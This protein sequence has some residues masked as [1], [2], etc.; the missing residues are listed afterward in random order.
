RWP[1]LSVIIPARNEANTLRITLPSLLSFYYPQA[2]IILVD[3]CS[4]DGTAQVAQEVAAAQGRENLRIITETEPPAGWRGKVWALE[5]GVRASTGE[6]LLFLDG[7]VS[8]TPHMPRDLLRSALNR[9]YRMASLMVLLRMESFWDR[10]LVPAFVF[11]FHTLYPFHWV[12]RDRSRTA[13]AAGG[14]ILIERAALVEAGG[15]E[16]VRDAWI[17]DVALAKRVKQNGAKVYLGITVQ[18]MSVR[19]YGTLES[20]RRMVTRSAF[21]QLQHSWILLGLTLAVMAVLFGVPFVDTIL[22]T[23]RLI[24]M[25]SVD[26]VFLLSASSGFS[27]GFMITAYSPFLRLYRMPVVW[28]LTLPA[29]AA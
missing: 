28:G 16:A 3:D 14:C 13:A 4:T 10:L 27:M 23:A 26:L 12:G 7:D 1:S 15:L 2:E 9:G 11:F 21:T 20:L 18:A 22:V 6:W 17:D 5:Q 19:R 25:R 24:P 29:A 8:C